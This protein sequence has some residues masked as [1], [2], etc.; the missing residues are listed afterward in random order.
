MKSVFAITSIALVAMAQQQ[1]R[2]RRAIEQLTP[3][4][5]AHMQ[6]TQK[7][8]R[9]DWI[10]AHPSR[11]STGMV[12]LPDLGKAKYQGEQGGL[13]PGGENKPPARH[14]KAGLALAKTIRPLDAEGRESADGKIVLMS[15]G[16]SNT[17]MK[18]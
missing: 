5:R 9:A 11:D 17:T 12:A 18:F 7:V 14:L 13:Y 4:E 15:V 8:K 16:M 3:E 10:A 2:N 1:D 6:A